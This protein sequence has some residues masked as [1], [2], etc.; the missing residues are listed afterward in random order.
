MADTVHVVILAGGAGERFWPASQTARPKPFVDL[1]GEGTLFQEALRRAADLARAEQTWVVGARAHAPLLRAEATTRI[2]DSHILLEPCRRDTAPAAALAAARIA[3]LDPEAV[4]VLMPSDH[5]VPDRDAFRSTLLRAVAA[6][7]RGF[8]TCVG[9]P[10]VR[11]ETRFG[12]VVAGCADVAPGVQAAERFVEKPP[13]AEA[14]RL[15]ASGQAYWNAGLLACRAADLCAALR[16]HA[17]QIGACLPDLATA[18]EAELEGLYPRLP[19][20]SLDYAVLQQAPNVAVARATFRWHD[21]G[22]W[23]ELPFVSA[24]AAGNFVRGPVRLVNTR[25]SVVYNASDQPVVVHGLERLL[26]AQVRDHVTL[27]A[28]LGGDTRQLLR[29]LETAGGVPEPRSGEALWAA[30]AAAT[31]PADAGTGKATHDWG[32]RLTWARAPGY[33][34]RAVAVHAGAAVHWPCPTGW[35]DTYWCLSGE[36]R[37]G[38]ATADDPPLR[39]GLEVVVQAGEAFSLAAVS[40]VLLLQLRTA[41]DAAGPAAPD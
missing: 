5:H 22:S 35:R 15:V 31:P 7:R 2:P 30:I 36:G 13:L 38:S 37:L 11:P 10:P 33:L 18:G 16:V 29:A 24:D 8:L 41:A 34:A 4:L 39:A 20:I 3:A 21:V 1:F 14:Q 26:V 19:A 32:F 28:P 12:Y 27:V 25:D 17:P 40:P 9:I 23:S 6:A